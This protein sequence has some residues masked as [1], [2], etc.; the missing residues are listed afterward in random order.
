MDFAQLKKKA[1]EL[2]EKAVE[3]TDKTLEQTAVKVAQSSLVLKEQSELESL[4]TKSENK[5]FITQE[6]QEKIFIKR[7]YL[8]V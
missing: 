5:Q 6:G 8:M 1:L 4:I 3:F 2:K 7:S